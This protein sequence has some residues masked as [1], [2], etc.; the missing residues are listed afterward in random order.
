[1]SRIP[2]LPIISA[3]MLTVCLALP[4]TAMAGKP[5]DMLSDCLAYA[6]AKQPQ[7]RPIESLKRALVYACVSEMDALEK[8]TGKTGQDLYWSHFLPVMVPLHPVE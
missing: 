4:A 8:A 2:R 7:H 5:S 1:M 3:A 6:A